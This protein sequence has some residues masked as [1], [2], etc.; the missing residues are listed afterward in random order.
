MLPNVIPPIIGNAFFVAFLKNSRREK[1]S[2]YLLFSS[3]CLK[4]LLVI[5]CCDLVPT[6]GTNSNIN[7]LIN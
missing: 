4:F 1:S 3:I 6:I 2:S 5:N 7:Q